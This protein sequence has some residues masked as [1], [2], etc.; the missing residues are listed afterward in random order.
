MK[1][2]RG[3]PQEMTEGLYLLATLAKPWVYPRRANEGDWGEGGHASLLILLPPDLN[4]DRMDGWNI[5]SIFPFKFNRYNPKQ[6]KTSTFEAQMN[7]T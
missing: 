4:I 2:S 3:R 1:T 5:V 6:T 7:N